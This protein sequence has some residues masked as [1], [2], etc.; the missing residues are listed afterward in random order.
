MAQRSDNGSIRRTLDHHAAAIAGLTAKVAGVDTTLREHSAILGEIRTA[1]TRH[2]ATKGLSVRDWMTVAC[3]GV[4]LASAFTAA[5]YFVVRPDVNEL[6]ST[7]SRLEKQ[8]EHAA[9]P[10]PAKII[11]RSK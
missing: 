3:Q 11:Y 8:I 5:V 6:R 7:V 2:E 9:R 4:F 1:I 10:E